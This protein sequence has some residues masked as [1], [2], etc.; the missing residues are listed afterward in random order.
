MPK[1][2]TSAMVEGGKATAGPP[3]GPALG[4]T[5]VNVKKV[6]DTINERT[7]DM[8]GMQVPVKVIV[9]TEKKTFEVVV[10]TPPVSAL[11]KKETNLKKGCKE[12]GIKRV[13]D[14]T[15]E[16]VSKIAKIKFGSDTKR[17]TSMVTGTARSMG[18]TVGKG[19]ITEEELR[20]Y[21]EMD[22]AKEAAAAAKE[23]AKVAAQA[24]EE[25]GEKA[26]EAKAPEGKEAKK[27]EEK[28]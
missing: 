27:T 11:I 10:G 20:R 7:K 16:Q 24:P 12:P 4:P 14:L 18:I 13:G 21:E 19:A 6:V 8:N 17:F 15:E 25:A 23:E 2:T 1:Q 22:R 9:D 26:E 28:K 5:G 3:L